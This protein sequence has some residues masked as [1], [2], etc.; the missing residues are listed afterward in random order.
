M[1]TY[2]VC[3]HCKNN[4]GLTKSKQ[5][6]PSSFRVTCVYCGNPDTYFATESF[7]ERWNYTCS[8]CNNKFY[9]T[10]PPPS[11]VTCPDCLAKIRIDYY[12]QISL[13]VPGKVKPTL[14]NDSTI[15]GG[16]LGAILG[17]A[18]GG[19]TGAIVGG[20]L[21]GALLGGSSGIKKAIEGW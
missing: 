3:H 21:G 16:L 13:H 11:N 15:A 1:G 5:E 10:L 17:A 6:L 14:R 9:R 8:S 18:V 7:E 4:I 12:D 2:V 20:I 19:P